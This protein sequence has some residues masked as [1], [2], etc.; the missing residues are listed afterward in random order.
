VVA[1]NIVSHPELQAYADARQADPTLLSVTVPL[2]HGLE[3]TTI[4]R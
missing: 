1:D 3:I 2:A 4:L